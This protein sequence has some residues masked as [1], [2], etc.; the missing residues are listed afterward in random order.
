MLSFT[1]L[2]VL[3]VP[4]VTDCV[5]VKQNLHVKLLYKGSPLPLP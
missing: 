4:E 3:N 2:N 5:Q 1:T